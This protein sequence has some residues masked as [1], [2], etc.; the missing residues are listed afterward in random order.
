MI[1]RELYQCVVLSASLLAGCGTTDP[2][3]DDGPFR[4][5]IGRYLQ[6]N[7]NSL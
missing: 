5:A 2:T 7:N 1:R 6:A 3:V 4:E